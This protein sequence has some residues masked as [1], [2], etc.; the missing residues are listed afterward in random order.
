VGSEADQPAPLSGDADLPLPC[1]SCNRTLMSMSWTL[2]ARPVGSFSL[3]GAQMKVSASSRA[4]VRC[5]GC[6]FEAHG[7]IDGARASADGTM[8][9]AGHFVSDP[10]PAGQ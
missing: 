5:R 1:P 4:V 3:A 7:T 8:L 6:A 10:P 9:V 2:V